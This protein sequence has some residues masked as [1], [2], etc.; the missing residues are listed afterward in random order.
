MRHGIVSYIVQDSLVQPEGTYPSGT[1]LID[2]ISLNGN[3]GGPVISSLNDGSGRASLIGIIQ[4]HLG[5]EDRQNMDLGTVVPAERI[6]DV[7]KEF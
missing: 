6:L 4:G 1:I 5:A 3:S 2:A 7:L